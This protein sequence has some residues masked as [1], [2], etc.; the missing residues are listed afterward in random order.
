MV[1]YGISLLMIVVAAALS[2][3]SPASADPPASV[4]FGSRLGWSLGTVTV[5]GNASCPGGGQAA[6]NFTG[7][8]YTLVGGSANASGTPPLQLAGPVFI[9]CDGA[10]HDWQ[11][12]A[13]SPGNVL[14]ISAGANGTATAT[15]VQGPPVNAVLAT[16]GTQPF[17]IG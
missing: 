8:M 4:S 5:Y 16:S 10:L 12:F 17:V 1:R 11:G 13:W 2:T 6:V 14:P 7:T 15:L 3:A 9:P